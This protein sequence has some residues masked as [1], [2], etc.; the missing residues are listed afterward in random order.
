MQKG[1]LKGLKPLIVQRLA[2]LIGICYLMNPLH[3]QINSVFHEVSHALETPDY[4]MSHKSATL[5]HESHSHNDYQIDTLQ[6]EHLLIDF[7]DSLFAASD[8][9]DG[10]DD[11]VLTQIK[12]DKHIT[13]YQ[14]HL[15]KEFNFRLLQKFWMA[16]EKSET[17]YLSRLKE[18]PQY[19]L[20]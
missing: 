16:L 5:A 11:S 15:Q 2:L 17:G 12:I 8:E 7:I 19:Y 20:I 4:I 1:F 18:P 9:N 6:H 10:S 14:Y 3:Q 13:T